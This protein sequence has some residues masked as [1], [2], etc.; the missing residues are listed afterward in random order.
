LQITAERQ[1]QTWPVA[2]LAYQG[3]G[4]LHY[5]W[6]ELEAAA[7]YLRLGI[8]FGQ[9]GGLT[10]LEINSCSTLAFTLQAQSDP[11]GADEMLRQLAAMTAQ[12]HH[13]V[14]AAIVAAREAHLRLRQGRLAPALR[15]AETCNLPLAEAGQSYSHESEYLT[16]ARV[17]IAHGQAETALDLLEP[18]CQA[19]EADQR[20]GSLSEILLLQALARHTQDD[21]SGTLT[22]LERALTLAEPEG[23]VRLFVDEGEPL[24]ELLRQAQSQGISPDYLNK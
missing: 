6:N 15:W 10:G 17:F 7:H 20:S 21:T 18:L 14:Y 24:A 2:G 23:Y 16:L 13:P 4:K 3:L 19:A 8:E 1:R 12:H 5:E 11:G 22:V 9:R